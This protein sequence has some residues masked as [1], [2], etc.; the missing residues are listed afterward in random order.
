MVLTVRLPG[1]PVLQLAALGGECYQVAAQEVRG[2]MTL[3]R[4]NMKKIILI[5]LTLSASITV[6][7]QQDKRLSGIEKE[8]N[9]ILSVT[10]A[11]GFAVAIEH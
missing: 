1:K 6:S 7:G 2:T 3:F 11:P 8:L 9:E 4:T 5:L 10:K